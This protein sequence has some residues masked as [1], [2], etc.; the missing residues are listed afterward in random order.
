M[1]KYIEVTGNI[2]KEEIV[3]VLKEHK[4]RNTFVVVNDEP[5]PGYH[6]HKIEELMVEKNRTVFLIT[7]KRYTWASIIRT[8]EKINRFLDEPIDASYSELMLFNVPHYAIRIKGLKDMKSLET[9]QRSYQ[10]EGFV[11]M[12][13]KRMNKPQ[14][15]FLKVKRFFDI[16]EVTEGIYKDKEKTS[17]I[18]L[19]KKI[20]WELFRKM[21][22][23]VK[24]NISD[25]NFD[26]VNGAFYMKHGLVDFIRI[27]KPKCDMALLEEIKREYE[28]QINKYY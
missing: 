6:Y 10:D 17:Y 18:L 19:D 22:I 13:N 16:K 14:T 27:F 7:R 12:K 24:R 2:N 4:L 9:I 20:E 11:F 8:T 3:Y 28:K 5:F 23:N 21:T 1:G 26:I 25:K 15:V